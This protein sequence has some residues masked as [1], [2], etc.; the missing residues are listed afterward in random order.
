MT[1]DANRRRTWATT[2]M[3]R[4]GMPKVEDIHSALPLDDRRELFRNGV[5]VSHLIAMC[6]LLDAARMQGIGSKVP[7]GILLDD[8]ASLLDPEDARALRLVMNV[9]RAFVDA[10]GM[11]C[12]GQSTRHRFSKTGL[13]LWARTDA[14]A[15]AY[16]NARHDYVWPI[17]TARV[18]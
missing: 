2:R 3:L 8:A 7:H 13:A 18:A 11:N 17:Q 1:S 14:L 5:M 12:H 4:H 6:R 16:F 10:A 15:D 9:R